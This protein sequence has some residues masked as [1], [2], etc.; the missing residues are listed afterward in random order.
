MFL[1][2]GQALTLYFVILLPCGVLF[3]LIGKD[4]TR[5]A[6]TG[7]EGM[8]GG[9]G[10]VIHPGAGPAKVFYKGEIWDTVSTEEISEGGTVEI[11]GIERMKL[12]VRNKVRNVL[13][14][15]KAGRFI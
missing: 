13:Q 1:P 2:F 3:W 7:I 6:S 15:E 8:I 11:I 9:I 4:M 14:V 12:R 10:R 5:P